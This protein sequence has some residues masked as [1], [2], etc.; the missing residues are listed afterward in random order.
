LEDYG[1]VLSDLKPHIETARAN[2]KDFA[3]IYDLRARAM[4]LRGDGAAAADLLGPLLASEPQIRQIWRGLAQSLPNAPVAEKWVERLAAATP[5]DLV[6]EQ[7][8][9]AIAWQALFE[10][11]RNARGEVIFKG[12]HDVKHKQAAQAVLD[13]LA[14]A[15]PDN[16]YVI[17]ARAI[18]AQQENQRGA[19]EQAY[20]RALELKQDLPISLNNL[21]MMVSENGDQKEALSLAQRALTILPYDPNILDSVGTVQLKLKDFSKA[22]VSF[23]TAAAYDPSLDRR[24][25]LAQAYDEANQ[26]QDLPPLLDEIERIMSDTK[27][28][29]IQRDAMQK[30]RSKFPKTARR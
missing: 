12:S 2:P 15:A 1:S 4:L 20:R 6:S 23:K 21:A 26:T 28:T 9:L 18:V 7:I 25:R 10:D 8:D 30:L 24:I 29:D 27:V 22:I 3:V 17:Q 14:T 16:P 13:R 19:A 5:P 11:R